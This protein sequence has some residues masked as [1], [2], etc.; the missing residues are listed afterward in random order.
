MDSL[1]VSCLMEEICNLLKHTS[2]QKNSGTSPGGGAAAET[3]ADGSTPMADADK[4]V[5]QYRAELKRV[6]IWRV[7]KASYGQGEFVLGKTPEEGAATKKV[8]KKVSW[9]L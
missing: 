8:V 7:L 9:S 2:G 3:P 4:E 6:V 1:D 5:N